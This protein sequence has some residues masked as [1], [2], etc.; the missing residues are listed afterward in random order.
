MATKSEIQTL[1]DT[2]LAS[3][4]DI[5]AAEHR[6]VLKDDGNSLLDE[7]YASV[8]TDDE[9]TTNVFTADNANKEYNLNIVKQGRKVRVSGT[10]NNDTGG[11]T[12]GFIT[13]CDITTTEYQQNSTIY[14]FTGV[15]QTDASHITFTLGLNSLGVSDP[16]ADGETVNIDFTYFT[17][18]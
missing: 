5:T 6:N 13:W 3:T 15:S 17:N 18:A 1:I 16:L 11:V 10:I 14:R 9:T 12:A 2:D 4:S 8:V 7:I